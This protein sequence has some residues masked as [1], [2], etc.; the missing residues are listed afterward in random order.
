MAYMTPRNVVHGMVVVAAPL[1]FVQKKM[2]LL[3]KNGVSFA[4]METGVGFHLLKCCPDSPLASFFFFETTHPR[5]LFSIFKSE[6][7]T[8]LSSNFTAL[9]RI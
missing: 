6:V 5:L 8:A 1:A 2:A 9:S 7:K 4:E 3:A